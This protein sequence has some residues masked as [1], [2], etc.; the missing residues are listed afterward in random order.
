MEAFESA[1]ALDVR[2]LLAVALILLAAT[3][4]G[5]RDEESASETVPV[6]EMSLG[7]VRVDE[8]PWKPPEPVDLT[9]RPTGEPRP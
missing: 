1:R 4:G 5:C 8:T 9:D 2:R 6:E 7:E 3:G